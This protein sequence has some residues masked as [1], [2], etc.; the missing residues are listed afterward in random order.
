ML[1][2]LQVSLHL[3]LSSLFECYHKFW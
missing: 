1:Q 2:T 3:R